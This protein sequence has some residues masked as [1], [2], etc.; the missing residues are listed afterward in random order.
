MRPY[1]VFLSALLIICIGLLSACKPSDNAPK[2]TTTDGPSNAVN[3]LLSQE[4]KVLTAEQAAERNL[5]TYIN[6]YNSLIHSERG[7]TET[8]RSFMRGIRNA[9]QLNN[10]QFPVVE[11][12]EATAETLR[13]NLD[14]PIPGQEALSTRAAELVKTL[15]VLLAS[16]SE[17]AAYFLDQQ[18]P[19]ESMQKARSALARMQS[20]YEVALLALSRLGDEILKSRRQIAEKRMEQ[21]REGDNMIAFHTEEIMIISEE[22]LALFDDPKVPFNRAVTFTRGNTLVIR[23][24]NAIKALRK[25][26]DDARSKGDKVNPYFDSIRNR[27]AGIITDYRE[28][29]D[30]RSQ[31]AFQNMLK[32]YDL[33]VQDYNSAQIAAMYQDDSESPAPG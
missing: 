6:A 29:R 10:I 18:T 8:Y 13:K 22:L 16:E 20:D 23:L 14:H 33:A 2:K 4:P 21:F 3:N 28:V 1:R 9:R 15:E 32:K 31:T 7:L 11:N 19:S 5:A 30:R 26:T 25:V 27:A 17:M 24:D 12:L